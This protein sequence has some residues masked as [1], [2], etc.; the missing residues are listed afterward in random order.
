MVKK[1]TQT[2]AENLLL[3]VYNR[4]ETEIGRQV[5]ESLESQAF[6][7]KN[8]AAQKLD[9]QVTYG[10][11]SEPV[12]ARV[13]QGVDGAYYAN[14]HGDLFNDSELSADR[15]AQLIVILQGVHEAMGKGSDARK[16]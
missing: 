11:R 15:I 5:R 8:M 10:T 12:K 1:L 4:G 13:F 7:E 9:F 3:D 2:Q 14:I 6:K 16:I